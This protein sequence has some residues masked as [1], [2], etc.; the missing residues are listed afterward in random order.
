MP[1]INQKRTEAS[2]YL[3][4]KEETG[5]G[6]VIPEQGIVDNGLGSNRHAHGS[7]RS[8]KIPVSSTPK[9]HILKPQWGIGAL[10]RVGGTERR[11]PLERNRRESEGG[12]GER[13][14]G[15]RE[16]SESWRKQRS[17]RKRRK[18]VQDNRTMMEEEGVHVYRLCQCVKGSVLQ[19]A[20]NVHV[21]GVYEGRRLERAHMGME[22]P[23]IPTNCHK[24]IFASGST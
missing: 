18:C 16:S 7:S 17:S 12:G 1:L 15:E 23:T 3:S 5:A 24:S 9:S 20:G 13:H 4:R 6:L 8:F 14:G 21:G 10:K 11:N 2:N 22:K 19:C